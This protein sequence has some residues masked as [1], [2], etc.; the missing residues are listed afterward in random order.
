MANQRFTID[1]ERQPIL[2]VS[3]SVEAKDIAAARQMAL[4]YARDPDVEWEHLMDVP[5]VKKIT[6]HAVDKDGQVADR[7][8]AALSGLSR[9]EA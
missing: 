7:N 4:T 8:P 5:F 6:A 3:V 9:R 2:R 1:L